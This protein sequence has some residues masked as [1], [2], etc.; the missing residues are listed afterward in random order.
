MAVAL[1][2]HRLRAAGGRAADASQ[3]R[4]AE[5]KKRA[6]KS[7]PAYNVE[8]LRLL[9]QSAAPRAEG[10]VNGLLRS[11]ID[12]SEGSA[13][14]LSQM[15]EKL[16]ASTAAWWTAVV[17]HRAAVLASCPQPSLTSTSAAG[18]SE[19]PWQAEAHRIAEELRDRLQRRAEE[20]GVEDGH[21]ADDS[22]RAVK[23]SRPSA[24][25]TL[26]SGR[27]NTPSALTTLVE[28]AEQVTLWSPPEVPSKGSG[29]A[30]LPP[31]A[32]EYAPAKAA[33]RA[34]LRKVKS[35]RLGRLLEGR[36]AEADMYFTI[37]GM[38]KAVAKW[39]GSGLVPLSVIEAAVME[40]EL[41]VM[42]T[43]FSGHLWSVRW[44]A[45]L[46]ARQCAAYIGAPRAV[47]AAMEEM[48]EAE[49]QVV[50]ESQIRQ[51]T[52]QSTQR[53]FVEVA[54]GRIWQR[55]AERGRA[56]MR[57]A[58]NQTVGCSGAG[59]NITGYQVLE[60][61]GGK[62][63]ITW[64][65]E[66]EKTAITASKALD[67]RMGQDPRR[68]KVM[69][70]GE[71][72]TSAMH[73][74]G[75]IIT[76]SCAPF[77]SQGN[78]ENV[79]ATFR[80]IAAALQAMATRRPK[81]VLLETTAGL[82]R[83]EENRRRL[84]MMVL[85]CRGYEWEQM[86]MSPHVHAG[87]AERRWRIGVMGVIKEKKWL[88]A[89][90]EDAGEEEAVCEGGGAAR[91][92]EEE[93]ESRE[94]KAA[95]RA[96]EMMREEQQWAHVWEE[97][98]PEWVT[99]V[100]AE[101]AATKEEAKV[102]AAKA[103]RAEGGTT[104]AEYVPL[105]AIG[106]R[107]GAILPAMGVSAER[108]DVLL[109]TSRIAEGV[110]RAVRTSTRSPR[111]AVES[112]AEARAARL[113]RLRSITGRTR[114][115]EEAPWEDAPSATVRWTAAEARAQA[116]DIHELAG[117]PAWMLQQTTQWVSLTFAWVD[118]EWRVLHAVAESALMRMVQE[119]GM[120]L[121]MAY[122]GRQRGRSHVVGQL[123]GA[124]KGKG[125]E[126]SEALA[127][128]V[129]GV[130]GD[131]CFMTADGTER[132]VF[133]GASGAAG[134]VKRSNDAHGVQGACNNAV[135]E[136]DATLVLRAQS[137]VPPLDGRASTWEELLQS[138]VLWDYGPDYWRAQEVAKA[139]AAGSSRA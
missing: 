130:R 133:D 58:S 32:S 12:G 89:E 43:Q 16:E 123:T 127:K 88:R 79:E 56:M 80:D 57:D 38:E 63:R 69:G 139:R 45:P 39:S 71:L 25:G 126:G 66:G 27:S 105:S 101:A 28:G 46:D 120:G 131:Y 8:V 1:G 60:W 52:G 14:A 83:V 33:Q 4:M 18:V 74:T 17:K 6:P 108:G 113:E 47:G 85:D 114:V 31:R 42:T 61:L 19:T 51:L 77:A 104:R 68:A 107:R 106:S 5:S 125:R 11:L 135:L 3:R 72:A 22:P 111:K 132:N 86:K 90:A 92:E 84:E 26:R 41:A 37:G 93:E 21:V 15:C 62:G 35:W 87:E 96:I 34:Q 2:H 129:A 7:K 99:R 116:E 110:P 55:L 122:H 53:G 73:T 20:A 97:D 40:E 98:W 102:E 75:E 112:A 29:G 76:G 13:E 64:V 82:W 109:T 118:E 138:E 100:Q 128:V 121:Y 9:R 50:S 23:K 49:P 119:P 124:W 54:M 70:S 65:E 134:G 24:V 67:A 137:W 94:E 10:G 136:P 36:A 91:M 30:A 48:V 59:L 117:L 115:V 95:R 81:W 78:G 44:E 103:A